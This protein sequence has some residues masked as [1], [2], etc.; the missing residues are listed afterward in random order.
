MELHSQLTLI[1]GSPL[2]TRITETFKGLELVHAGA[3]DA[4]IGITLVPICKT[5]SQA[6]ILRQ[7]CA[8]ACTFFFFF[9]LI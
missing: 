2:V 6:K 9:F 8:N 4:W 7:Y 5:R 3:I 1:A